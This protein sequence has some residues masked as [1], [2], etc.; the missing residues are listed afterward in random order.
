MR[1]LALK[2]KG[3]VIPYIH[4]AMVRAFGHLGAE[5]ENIPIEEKNTDFLWIEEK[6]KGPD[7]V[8]F[9]LNMG[10]DQKFLRR[11]K[12]WQLKYRRP[13]IIWFVDDPEGYNFP[14]V[15]EPAYTLAFC[16]D[17]GIINEISSHLGERGVPLFHLPLAT[18]PKVFFPLIPKDYSFKQ[19]VFV[20]LLSPP[21][22]LFEEI[23]RTMPELPSEIEMIWTIYKQD[24]SIPLPD[25]LW[26][27][28]SQKLKQD[29]TFLKPNWLA[30]LWVKVCSFQLGLKKRAEVVNRVLGDQGAVFG[31][32]RWMPILKDGI[33]HGRI[34]YGEEL[35]KIYSQATF[36]LDIRPA[37]SR[38]GL[39]QRVFDAS[40]SGVPVLTEWSSELETLFDPQEEVFFFRNL[41]EAEEV[42]NLLIRDKAKAR[43]KAAKAREKTLRAHTYLCRAGHILEKWRK[44]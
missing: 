16:W 12:E 38:T 42:R 40:A 23:F 27:I 5:V 6:M 8:I 15:C 7:Q 13:W 30:R 10:G 39:T 18:D 19:G 20:G 43:K 33:Y 36:V 3:R 28:L 24:F 22:E 31:D 32:E 11:V 2:P 26:E 44:F 29:I 21:N 14:E 9:T 17:K 25:L 4:E 37:Q 34:K 35:N 1:I 41:E